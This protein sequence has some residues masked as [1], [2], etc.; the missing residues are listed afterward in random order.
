MQKVARLTASR[1]FAKVRSHA[2][3][4]KLVVAEK[5]KVQQHYELPWSRHAGSVTTF[6]IVR[7]GWLLREPEWF[8]VRVSQKPTQLPQEAE[9]DDIRRM[10]IA[11]FNDGWLLTPS[12]PKNEF[13]EFMKQGLLGPTLDLL[14]PGVNVFVGS[15]VHGAI[16]TAL[17]G[18]EQAQY[19]RRTLE[20]FVGIPYLDIVEIDWREMGSFWSLKLRG[21]P[22]RHLTLV[23]E[24]L[25]TPRT[26]TTLIGDFTF[27]NWVKQ[28]FSSRYIS[29]ARAE[30]AAVIDSFLNAESVA[31]ITEALKER[32][33]KAASVSEM[34]AV[35]SDYEKAR[36]EYL[37][38]QGITDAI[39]HEETI[40]RS[41][42]ELERYAGLPGLDDFLAQLKAMSPSASA[43]R[44]D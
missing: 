19:F 41:I 27:V 33:F 18:K 14:M 23:Y 44:P 1:S 28:L 43:S 22:V 35:L 17:E 31:R 2:A 12:V 15:A 10:V 32:Y 13:W 9:F 38:E 4:K 21:G 8:P 7:S 24:T 5:L 11:P 29:E 26:T 40:R 3:P 30:R 37:A 42:K 25:T 6:D 39:V 20:Q 34:S 36:T 16:D